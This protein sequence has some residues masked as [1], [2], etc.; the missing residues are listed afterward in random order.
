MAIITISR[1]SYSMGKEVAE[2]VAGKLGYACISRDILLDA[3]E[4]FN[5]PEI[6]LVKAIE[7]SPSI[8]DRFYNGKEMYVAYIQAALL[9]YLHEDNIVYHGM[10]GHF[11][12]K[13]IGHVLNVR[14]IAE[15]EDR[16]KIVM[17]RENISRDRAIKNIKKID[18]QRRKWSLFLYGIDTWDSSL[19]DLVIHIKKMTTDDA[20]DM[21]CHAASLDHFKTTAQSRAKI[22]GLALAA[23]VRAALLDYHPH[24]KTSAENG[25]VDIVVKVNEYQ[26]PDL[27]DQLTKRAETVSGVKSVRI[28]LEPVSVYTD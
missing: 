23:A 27:S 13:D 14:I 28:H 4:M 20:A 9:K 19:Y 2:K 26:K 3:S 25:I 22:E 11:F 16:V 10:A 5:V 17:E 7:D 1:G 6:K 15:M 18:E 8:L 12:V 21:I 24:I